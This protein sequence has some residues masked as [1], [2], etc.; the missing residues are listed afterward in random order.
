MPAAI[1][2]ESGMAS[3]E[4]NMEK[5]FDNHSSINFE[6]SLELEDKSEDSVYMVGMLIADV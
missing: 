6:D 4:I 3:P 2:L 1:L 5:E